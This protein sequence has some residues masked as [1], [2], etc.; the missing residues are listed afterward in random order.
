MTQIFKDD[1]NVIP[2]TVVEVGPCTVLQVKTKEKDGY[3]AVQLGFRDKKKSRIKKAEIGHSKAANTAAKQRVTEMRLDD[4]T[5]ADYTVGQVLTADLL[6]VGDRIDVSGVSIG[7]GYQGVV[8]RW[9]MSG[10][11][12]SHGTHEFFRHGGSIGNRSDPSKVFKNKHMA[13]QMGNKA[14]TVQNLEVVSV[15]ADKN[16]VLVRG[17]VPGSKNGYVVVK[18]SVKGGFEARSVKAADAQA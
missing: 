11:P 8:K 4:K 16:L 2:V 3:N 17:A 5:V 14:I 10:M 7:K 12:G 9:G 6:K 1:G 13:G 15:E 18:A